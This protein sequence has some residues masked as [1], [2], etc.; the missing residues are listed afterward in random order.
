M[1]VGQPGPRKVLVKNETGFRSYSLEMSVGA[2]E[3]GWGGKVT[4]V[5]AWVAGG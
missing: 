1:E 2:R 5:L 4:R 3:V